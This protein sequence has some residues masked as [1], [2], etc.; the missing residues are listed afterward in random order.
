MA[1]DP[2]LV[3]RISALEQRVTALAAKLKQDE[4]NLG[5][6]LTSGNANFLASLRKLPHQ[7]TSNSTDPNTGPNWG[8]GERD[9]IN[10]LVNALNTLQ[11]N[12][13][14]NGFES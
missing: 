5:N 1:S 9:Y 14:G 4:E 6:L 13:Q 11:S 10:G 12:L 8:T 2:A 3:A 7:T